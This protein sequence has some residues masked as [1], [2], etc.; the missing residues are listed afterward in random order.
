MRLPIRDSSVRPGHFLEFDCDGETVTLVGSEG[1]PVGSLT[2]AAVVA[3]IH[4]SAGTNAA[5][6][7]RAYSRASLALKVRYPAGD[8]RPLMS[9]TGD[10]SGGGLFIETGTP[11]PQG[12]E[13][14]V[15]FTMPDPPYEHVQATAQV[16]WA[17]KKA[18]R[19]VF[20]PG[21]G[22][23]FT[24]IPRESRSRLQ[25]LVEEVHQVRQPAA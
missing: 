7:S 6:S 12:T 22:I 2:W 8:N 5:S 18:E 4:K 21:M 19:Y 23:K 16:V 1:E 10:V 25:D 9:V 24:D 20:L 13:L 14:T 15:D 17:R 3:F 11:L